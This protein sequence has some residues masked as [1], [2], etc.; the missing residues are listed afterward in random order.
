MN[1]QSIALPNFGYHES[2]AELEIYCQKNVP[3][4]DKS[5][6]A[7]VIICPG[8]S[9]EFLSEREAEPVASAFVAEG[10]QA[11]VLKYSVLKEDAKSEL[12]PVPLYELAAAF[13]YVRENSEDWNID[14]NRI[15]LAGFSAG[16]HLS[17]VYNGVWHQPWLS[18]RLG[19][20]SDR[21]RPNATVL[22]YPVIRFDM[23][24]PT[25]KEYAER[26]STSPDF[27]YADQ[28]VTEYNSP[29]FIWHTVTDKTVPV[30]NS[31]VYCE[32]LVKK[33]VSY[34]AHFYHQGKHGLSLANHTSAAELTCD[35]VNEHVASWLLLCLEWL[36]ENFQERP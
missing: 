6:M 35:Y 16:G 31:L 14:S 15:V 24:W 5:K 30:L 28:L 32:A 4:E 19:V 36:A 18:E 27:Q 26:I 1:P 13:K 34:E 7:A 3:I 20:H 12:F 8:G 23:G 29:T 33:Q 11:F 9:Y 21:L 10:Y 17:A 25:K 22:C 2:T